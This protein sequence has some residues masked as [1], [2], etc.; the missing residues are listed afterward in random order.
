MA[1]S[2]VLILNNNMSELMTSKPQEMGL[3]IRNNERMVHGQIHGE[4]CSPVADENS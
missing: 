2:V 3:R 1:Q 4:G